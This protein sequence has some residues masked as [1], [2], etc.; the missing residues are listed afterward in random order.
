MQ[1]EAAASC[2]SSGRL[3]CAC[4]SYKDREKDLCSTALIGK[5]PWARLMSNAGAAQV[6]R[7]RAARVFVKTDKVAA[8]RPVGQT[9]VNIGDL[10]GVNCGR[11]E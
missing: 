3:F 9:S 10:R 4:R 1:A 11:L 2:Q 7:R 8:C 6:A 5:P